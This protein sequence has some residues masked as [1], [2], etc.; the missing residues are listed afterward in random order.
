[1]RAH[2]ALQQTGPTWLTLHCTQQVYQADSVLNV[3]PHQAGIEHV[4]HQRGVLLRGWHACAALHA[5]RELPYTV[6]SEPHVF[7]RIT[8]Q[9]IVEP[10]VELSIR[11]IQVGHDVQ[12][13]GHLS[14]REVPLHTNSDMT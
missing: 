10:H 12:Q 3:A 9:Q 11:V 1:M 7:K 6:F 13:V 4:E 5:L 2:R 14:T 8:L